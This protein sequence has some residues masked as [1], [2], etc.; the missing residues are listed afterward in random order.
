MHRIDEVA[1]Q[2]TR[3]GP[4]RPGY[5]RFRHLQASVGDCR[6][7]VCVWARSLSF[8]A[9]TRKLLEVALFSTATVVQST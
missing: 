1:R 7:R 6:R 2:T 8:I 9:D 4:S 3:I 5:R